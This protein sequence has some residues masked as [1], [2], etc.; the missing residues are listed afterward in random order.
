MSIIICTLVTIMTQTRARDNDPVLGQYAEYPY[1]EFNKTHEMA[2]WRYYADPER[3]GPYDYAPDLSL[4]N[5]NHYLY[6]GGE[7][8]QNNF[9][10][11]IAGGGIGGTTMFLAEQLAHTNAEIIYIDFSPASMKIAQTRASMR[12]CIQCQNISYIRKI[13]EIFPTSSS[14][15]TA[16]KTYLISISDYLI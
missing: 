10:V 11:L 8:F 5:L 2:E 3:T 6:K 7:D 16:L 13:S 1:P 9:R 15:M 4:E 12:Y 14:S